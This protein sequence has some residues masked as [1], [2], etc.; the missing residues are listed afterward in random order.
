MNFQESPIPGAF[1]IDL[2]KRGDE[3]G[4]FARVFCEKEFPAHGLVTHF[5]Q[6][7]TSLRA[8]RA[9]AIESRPRAAE[10]QR[11]FAGASSFTGC[12]FVR[13]LAAAGCEVTATLRQVAEGYPDELRRKRVPAL[14]GK[15]RIVPGVSF[16][17]EGF[18]ELVGQGRFDLL[19]HHAADVRNYKSPDFDTVE[20]LANNTRNLAAV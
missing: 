5:V 2:E 4:F 6:V 7:N 20:A 11:L 3:R 15:C 14:A 8:T 12:W 17:D 16:G 18:L 10:M 13:E 1:L 19:A 9:R